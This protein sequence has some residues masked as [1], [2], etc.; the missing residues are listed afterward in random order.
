MHGILGLPDI[1]RGR[2]GTGTGKHAHCIPLRH[3]NLV[4]ASFPKINYRYACSSVVDPNTGFLP[5]L[6]LDPGPDP[7]LC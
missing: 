4:L 1:W 7:M 3:D 6:D 5:Y 2:I